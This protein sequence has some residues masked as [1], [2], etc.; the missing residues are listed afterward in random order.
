MCFS[1]SYSRTSFA[2]GLDGR[3]SSPHVMPKMVS[4]LWRRMGRRRSAKSLDRFTHVDSIVEKD[5][6]QAYGRQLIVLYT[7]PAENTSDC[8]SKCDTAAVHIRVYSN[9]G[10]KPDTCIFMLHSSV[11]SVRGARPHFLYA[12]EMDEQRQQQ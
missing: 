10:H 4:A 1:L 5:A 7:L 2:G 9:P 12:F 11:N 8:R 3:R 6:D